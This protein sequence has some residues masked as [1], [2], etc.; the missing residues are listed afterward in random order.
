LIGFVACFV[1][2]PSPS[3]NSNK[4]TNTGTKKR[5]DSLSP[6]FDFDVESRLA[7]E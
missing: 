7:A 2:I 5:W 1:V 3:N 6:S 4:I